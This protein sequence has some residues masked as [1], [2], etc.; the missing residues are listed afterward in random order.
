LA[1]AR[2]EEEAERD[3]REYLVAEQPDRSV[4]QWR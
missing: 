3:C 1:A 2:L 4:V